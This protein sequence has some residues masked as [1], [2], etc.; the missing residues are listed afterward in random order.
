VRR[1]IPILTEEQKKMF[2]FSS[3][4]FQEVVDDFINAITL[5]HNPYSTAV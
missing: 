4:P 3:K 1:T 5:R 2:S